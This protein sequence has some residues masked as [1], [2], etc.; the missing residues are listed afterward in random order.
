[1]DEVIAMSRRELERIAVLG[2]VLERRL[3]QARAAKM[4]DLSL[5][6]VKR[7][8]SRLREQGPLGMA[9]GLRGLPSNHQLDPMLLEAALSALHDPLWEGFGPTFARD[10]LRQLCGITLG[11]ETLR[12]LMTQ[13]GLW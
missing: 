9:H 2:K 1:M 10:K 12:Q 5:R 13:T 6:Q 7:L 4:L 8:C 3:T 11:V